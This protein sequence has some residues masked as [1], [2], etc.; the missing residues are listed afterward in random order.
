MTEVMIMARIQA[1][2]RT[3][4]EAEALRTS[5]VTVEAK[6]IEVGSIDSPLDQGTM[7]FAPIPSNPSGVSYSGS[8]AFGNAGVVVTDPSASDND[9]VGVPVETRSDASIVSDRD[10]IV[11][12]ADD[13]VSAPDGLQY[14]VSAVVPE[15][16]VGEAIAMIRNRGGYVSHP[17]T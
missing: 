9:E 4:N 17:T 13:A 10:A 1:Y 8:T 11:H 12:E 3:E 5:L 15:E 14:V 2:T 7:V 16:R 6:Q